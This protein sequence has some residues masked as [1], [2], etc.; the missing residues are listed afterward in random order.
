MPV[1]IVLILFSLISPFLLKL[2]VTYAPGEMIGDIN[3]WLGFLGGYSGGVLAFLAAYM[4]FHKQRA[5]NVRPFLITEPSLSD[6]N[7]KQCLYF[8]ENY[9]VEV[10]PVTYVTSDPNRG[11]RFINLALKNIGIGPALD[12]NIFNSKG[13]KVALA[14]LS[15]GVFQEFSSLGHIAPN[16]HMSWV[17][18]I[19]TNLASQSGEYKEE[20]TLEYKDIYSNKHVYKLH[21]FLNVP[22]GKAG[23]S[24]K[25]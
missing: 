22:R 2:Y 23:V 14:D 20:L 11:D 19:D 25:T 16:E 15:T 5:E 12:V 7:S 3:G 18:C 9:D 24:L 8:L 13:K 1:V 4:I 21:T 17:F 6:K 10:D